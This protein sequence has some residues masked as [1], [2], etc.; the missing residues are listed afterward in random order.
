MYIYICI[1]THNIYIYIYIYTHINIY[2]YIYIYIPGLVRAAP[3]GDRHGELAL[4]AGDDL[5]RAGIDLGFSNG[6]LE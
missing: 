6:T 4:P 1:H 5:C 2:T 3:D